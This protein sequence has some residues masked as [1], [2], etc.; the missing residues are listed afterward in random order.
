MVEMETHSDTDIPEAVMLARLVQFEQ[1]RE[2]FIQMWLQNPA[3]AECAGRKV[4]D[5]LAPLRRTVE[6]DFSG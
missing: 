6:T 4:Q 2:F 5:I 1:M 3:L